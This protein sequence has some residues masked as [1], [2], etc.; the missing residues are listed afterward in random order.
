M[1]QLVAVYGCQDP[2]DLAE[3]TNRIAKRLGPQRT[4]LALEAIDALGLDDL[5]RGFL[6]TIG[7]V[8]KG[9]PVG[10]DTIAATMNEDAGTLEDVVEPY[11]LQIG[12][13]ARTRR[14]R[15]LTPA[16]CA[17]LGLPALNVPLD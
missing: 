8:Y 4:A 14:G 15:A 9:G 1:A 12:F 17:H 13:L 10:L 2:T 11:L 16:A 5:D 3:A 6:K 7:T